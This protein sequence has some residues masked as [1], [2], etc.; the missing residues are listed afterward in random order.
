MKRDKKKYDI[1][2]VG[3]GSSGICSALAA[4][5]MG[6]AV[7]LIE[8][9]STLGGSNTLSLVGPLMGFHSGK[10]Q[11]VK[12]I[13]QEIIDQLIKRNGTLGHIPDPLGVSSSITP[14]DAKCLTQVYFDLCQYEETLSIWFQSILSG[15]ILD[16]GTIKA[17]V[18][19]RKGDLVEVEA[20]VFIDAS[21]DGDLASMSGCR[22][23]IGR[24]IDNMSQPMT[25]LFTVSGVNFT[26]IRKFMNAHPD[27][28]ILRKGAL[29][30]SYTAV[31][32][33]FNIVDQAKKAG[34]FPIDRDRV[35]FF[36]GVHEGE[37]LVNMS[38]VCG[39]SSLDCPQ[40]S[41][42]QRLGHKQVDQIIA[43]LRK[44]IDGFQDVR[45]LDVGQSI[46]V[47][48][49]RHI[50]GL[51]TLTEEDVRNNASFKDSVAIGAFPI[52]IHDPWGRELFW[53]DSGPVCYDVPYRTMVVPDIANLLI[54][55]RC[56][57]A[58]H[59][60]SASARITPTSMALGQAA[61][62]AAAMYENKDVKTINI[63]EL[64]N[65]LKM[66]GA[67]PGKKYLE[68]RG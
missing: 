59:I 24:A 4:A 52:D 47:R 14:V 29:D 40:A 44:Y 68:S 1:I 67:I 5:R 19:S 10:R 18:V 63:G 25:M 56:I 42:A 34:D 17:V 30:D 36:Q 41:A 13:A 11:V 38:R 46:G 66:A 32:G 51:Y 37:A 50:C 2:V 58:T 39:L 48:E 60:A 64:Q 20:S 16:N 31:S 23:H 15:V 6:K 27:Q 57:S 45:L 12:G 53:E 54:T 55:G 7:L 21:G 62:V 8:S 3:A 35:L 28:F 61:G 49:S 33:Y 9:S 43:F 65:K 22:Y 26:S